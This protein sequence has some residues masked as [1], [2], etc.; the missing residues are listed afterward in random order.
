VRRDHFCTNTEKFQLYPNNR[1]EYY[2]F[3]IGI[4]AIYEKYTTAQHNFLFNEI[5]IQKTLRS[6][7]FILASIPQ[8][9]FRNVLFGRRFDSA[10]LRK[11][12]VGFQ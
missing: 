2:A 7:T 9:S 8:F 10:S 6:L 5:F 4:I 3:F 11:L 12:E 1:T